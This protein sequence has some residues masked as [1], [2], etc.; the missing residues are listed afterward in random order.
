MKYYGEGSAEPGMHFI[1]TFKIR[2]KKILITMVTDRGGCRPELLELCQK[3]EEGEKSGKKEVKQVENREEAKRIGGNTAIMIRGIE[4]TNDI[5]S[6]ED[7]KYLT[8]TGISLGITH[9]IDDVK[10]IIKE[11]KILFIRPEIA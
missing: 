1:L 4:F 8:C 9:V 6:L 5:K 10:T 11:N 7:G 2:V 3:N